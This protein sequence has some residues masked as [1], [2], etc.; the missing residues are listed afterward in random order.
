MVKTPFVFAGRAGVVA[1][2]APG[3]DVPSA[4]QATLG[5]AVYCS[6][7]PIARRTRRLRQLRMLAQFLRSTRT[8]LSALRVILAWH[9]ACDAALRRRRVPR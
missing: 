5:I 3:P 4:P 9:N 6:V 8:R 7:R 1:L 2:P